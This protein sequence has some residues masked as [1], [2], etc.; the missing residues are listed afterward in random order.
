MCFSK[1]AAFTLIELLVVIAIIAILAALLMPAL[2]SARDTAYSIQC[3]NNLKQIANATFLYLDDSN[4]YFFENYGHYPP[5]PANGQGRE[6]STR[7][8]PVLGMPQGAFKFTDFKPQ[9]RCIG[10]NQPYMSFNGPVST[11]AYNGE[12]PGRATNLTGVVRTAALL[13][14]L[15]A[16]VDSGFHIL[17]DVYKG[18]FT[19]LNPALP[20]HGPRLNAVYCDGHLESVLPSV[21]NDAAITPP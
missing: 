14:F 13:M 16:P 18:E 17:R 6:W 12:L 5:Y 11:F 19:T 15:D 9:W 4:G 10:H 20:W 8:A 3:G 21:V 1:G 2:K 7:L